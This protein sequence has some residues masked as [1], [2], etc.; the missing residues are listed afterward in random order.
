[1]SCGRHSPSKDL[2]LDNCKEVT[3][4]CLLGHDYTGDHSKQAGRSQCTMACRHL[5][6]KQDYKVLERTAWNGVRQHVPP[7]SWLYSIKAIA[8]RFGNTMYLTSR[9]QLCCLICL[10]TD[11]CK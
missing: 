10:M 2:N 7:F 11:A 1:M 4:W 8:L 6:Q 3:A 5:L 9:L